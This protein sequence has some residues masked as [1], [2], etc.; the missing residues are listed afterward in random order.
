MPGGVTTLQD[1]PKHRV[2]RSE[3]G[4][5]EVCEQERGKY[6]VAFL[7]MKRRK[8]LT[9]CKAQG[10]ESNMEILGVNDPSIRSFHQRCIFI[11][12]RRG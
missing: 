4:G 7:A 10:G 6:D 5:D 2:D 11:L 3:E 12:S 8:D 9:G 1:V